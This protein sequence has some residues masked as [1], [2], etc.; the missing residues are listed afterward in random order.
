MS[1]CCMMILVIG[2]FESQQVA[3]VSDHTLIDLT[4]PVHSP[5]ARTYSNCN[6]PVKKILAHSFLALFAFLAVDSSNRHQT[7]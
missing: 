4:L 6:I 5:I 7:F 2:E 3:R 1:Y